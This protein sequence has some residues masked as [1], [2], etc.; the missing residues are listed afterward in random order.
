MTLIDFGLNG[1]F[2]SPQIRDCGFKRS[3]VTGQG[4]PVR[5]NEP[6]HMYYAELTAYSK[7]KIAMVKVTRKI[8]SQILFVENIFLKLF[9]NF[10]YIHKQSAMTSFHFILE[11]GQ[12]S[13]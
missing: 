7:F 4:P 12:Q 13:R 9:S 11:I 2:S 3:K 8:C 1:Q 10:T 6:Y 5:I